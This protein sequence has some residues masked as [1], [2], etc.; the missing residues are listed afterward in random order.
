[1]SIFN[2]DGI[3]FYFRDEGHGL[4]FVFQHG[5]SGD[6]NPPLGVYRTPT[7]VRLI[8][9]DTRAHGETRPLGEVARLAICFEQHAADVQRAIDDFLARHFYIAR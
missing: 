4:P 9:F 6:L 7:G 2:R 8:A 5:L 1:M 3:G